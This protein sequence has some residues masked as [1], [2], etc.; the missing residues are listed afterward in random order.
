MDFSN[1]S[2][3]PCHPGEVLLDERLGIVRM[4]ATVRLDEVMSQ[5]MTEYD[6]PVYGRLASVFYCCEAILMQFAK[7]MKVA[8]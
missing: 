4:L 2:G 5:L 3:C 6:E 8:E 1:L 7:E